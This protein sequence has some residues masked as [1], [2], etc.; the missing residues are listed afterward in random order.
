VGVDKGG[1]E[2]LMGERVDKN[3]KIRRENLWLHTPNETYGYGFTDLQS[4]VRK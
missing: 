2:V 3:V 1:R 4:R